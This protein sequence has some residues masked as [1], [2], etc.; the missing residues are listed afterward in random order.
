MA[1]FQQIVSRIPGLWSYY[2]RALTIYDIHSPYLADFIEA[3]FDSHYS[4]YDFGILSNARGILHQNKD[5]IIGTS[6][7]EN[8]AQPSPTVSAFTKRAASGLSELKKLYRLCVFSKPRR[9]LELGTG[10]GLSSLAMGLA[11]KHS[12]IDTVE[13]NANLCELAHSLHC[14]YQ[15]SR[16]RIHNVTIEEFLQA[17]PN[18][19]F[20][21]IFLDAHHEGKATV[22]YAA[23]L[24]PMLNEEGILLIDD[25]HWSSD[26]NAAWKL[27]R[28]AYWCTN[29]LE[30]FRWGFVFKT[31]RIKNVHMSYIP[32][33]W[34]FWRVGLW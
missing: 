18:K 21:L 12:S 9:I 16:I 11:S 6:K 15:L 25:I 2:K 28:R 19:K 8:R 13:M 22:D 7:S 14:R 32:Y 29:T 31:D 34:K 30:T 33:P 10:V 27:V 4:Y 5:Q 17:N 20:D 23:R 1:N 26:M 24:Y 3:V